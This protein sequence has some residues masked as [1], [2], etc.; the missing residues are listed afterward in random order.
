MHYVCIIQVTCKL[1]AS[2]RFLP[3]NSSGNETKMLHVKHTTNVVVDNMD[4][5]KMHFTVLFLFWL[6]AWPFKQLVSI[7][8]ALSVSTEVFILVF[9]R[10]LWLE[11]ILDSKFPSFVVKAAIWSVVLEIVTGAWDCDRLSIMGPHQFLSPFAWNYRWI[12][13]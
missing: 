11:S 2:F 9:L 12:S 10:A 6:F 13:G 3:Y 1:N 5:N 4:N 8:S 7:F